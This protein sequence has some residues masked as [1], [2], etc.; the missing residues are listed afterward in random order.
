MS[1]K[2]QCSRVSTIIGGTWK[3]PYWFNRWL[4]ILGMLSMQGKIDNFMRGEID[5][6]EEQE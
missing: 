4:K 3:L 2:V 1:T 5:A 6:N